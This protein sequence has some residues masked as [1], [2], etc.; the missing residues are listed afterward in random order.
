MAS[1]QPPSHQPPRKKRLFLVGFLGTLILRKSFSNSWNLDTGLASFPDSVGFHVLDD[2]LDK[3]TLL[4]SAMA[5]I[6]DIRCSK[7]PWLWLRLPNFRSLSID[8]PSAIS[9]I[10]MKA[11]RMN[12]GP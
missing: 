5:E 9:E 11:L 1:H 8:P 10:K 3:K 7:L 2:S 6:N 4:A 12:L